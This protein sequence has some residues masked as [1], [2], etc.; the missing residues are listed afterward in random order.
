[1]T[2]GIFQTYICTFCCVCAAMSG[3]GSDLFAYRE[4]VSE[5]KSEAG[6]QSKQ[7]DPGL[8]AFALV[9]ACITCIQTHQC[10]VW[11]F[12]TGSV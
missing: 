6:L 4:N 9:N 10:A 5:R 2:N 12:L 1:M 11:C 7:N 3:C 8:R